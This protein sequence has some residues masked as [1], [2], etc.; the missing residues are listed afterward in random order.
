VRDLPAIYVTSAGESR[1]RSNQ[2]LLNRPKAPRAA[3]S[4][5][6]LPESGEAAGWERSGSVRIFD[7]A[8]LW[9]Y[10]DGGAE[11]YIQAGV[12]GVHTAGYRYRERTEATADVYV[13]RAPESAR[14]LFDGESAASARSAVVGDASRLY[15]ASLTFRQGR[16]FVRL[17]AYEKTT[18]TA[19]A[20]TALAKV[21]E[22][23]LKQ[24]ALE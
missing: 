6:L 14:R 19:E 8:T 10:L 1:S 2:F 12:E 24:A 5:T 21:L 9:Q 7:A 20:L 4:A 11:R 13:M 16:C 18:E 3:I 17:T 22:R 23:R 15:A